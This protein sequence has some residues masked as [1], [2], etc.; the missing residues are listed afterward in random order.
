MRALVLGASGQV[1][2]HLLA[3]L[4]ERGHA[5]VGTRR[6]FAASG[7]P[8]LDIAEL[9]R[10]REAVRDTE[11]EAVFLPAG[12]TWVDGCEKD[13]ARS[14]RENLEQP[15]AVARVCAEAGA[16]FV[17]YSTDYVFDGRHGPYAEADVPAPLQVYGRDKLAC[18]QALATEGIASLVVRTTTVFGPERQGK[19]FVLQLVSK[20][21][22]GERLKVACDQLAT[23]SYGPDVARA[24]LELVEA[25]ARGVVHVAGPDLLDRASFALLACEVLGLDARTVEP[26]TTEAQA[27]PALRP[28]RAGLRASLL[29]EL[30][31]FRPRSARGG[32]EALRDE[33][34]R[35]G[36]S[37]ERE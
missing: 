36:G 17:W 5:A 23:P 37:P 8:R 32:L 1:G 7:L 21:R 2:G 20:A 16:L 26:V 22:A 14:A 15:L 18:E 27:A 30:T 34:V 6:S 24:T 29:F 4:L 3:Q 25:G 9:A 13:P 11:A 10:V 31:G 28:L 19:N 12:F 33:L 35:S